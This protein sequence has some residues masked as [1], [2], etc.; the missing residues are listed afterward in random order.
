M[1]KIL[2][3][4]ESK[5][6]RLAI[7]RALVHAGY[8]AITLADSQAA[9][10]TARKQLPDLI[11]LDLPTN[12]NAAEM[13]NTLK[14]E[15]RTADLATVVFGSLSTMDVAQ[16]Q[17]LGVLAVWEKAELGLDKGG[18][19]LLAQLSKLLPLLQKAGRAA[20]GTS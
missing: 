13:V 3:V 17:Q 8:D 20:A 14:R 16:L 10:E 9:V 1:M 19:V 12:A 5:F 2:L 15:A 18:K 7:G 6:L 11:L 4:E